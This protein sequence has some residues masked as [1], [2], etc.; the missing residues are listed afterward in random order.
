MERD[1]MGLNSKD[2]DVVVKEEIVEDGNDNAS[3]KTLGVPWP[4]PYMVS[5]L[6]HFMFLKSKHDEKLPKLKSDPLAPSGYTAKS[7]ADIFDVSHNQLSRNIQ[8]EFSVNAAHDVNLHQFS[9]LKPFCKTHFTSVGQNYLDATS[10]QRF[11]GGVPLLSPHSIRPTVLATGT[12]EQWVDSK[13]SDAPAQLTIFYAGTVNVFDGIPPE[14]AQAIMLLAGNGGFAQPKL[15][16]QAP[17]FQPATANRELINQTISKP[18][19]LGVSSPMSVSSY[20]ID[21]SGGVSANKNNIEVSNTVGI[22]TTLDGKVDTPRMVP[23]LGSVSAFATISSAV[24]QARKAS[25]AR[26]LEKRRE[27][28]MNSAPYSLSK[29]AAEG[30]ILQSDGISGVSSSSVSTSDNI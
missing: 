11:L 18:S 20:P 5:T 29:N 28:V 22:L 8:S 23:S 27:R 30:G 6:P 12:T 10:T 26:F 9:A 1:F 17:N 21:Q 4:F 14:K 13:T 3:T 15:H 24:P 16:L 25:L 7:A 19:S 2:S